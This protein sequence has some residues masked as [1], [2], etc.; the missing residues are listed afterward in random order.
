MSTYR[1]VTARSSLSLLL[2]CVSF[3]AAA[4]TQT[5]KEPVTIH[6]A[7][8]SLA[9]PSKIYQQWKPFADYIAETA[10]YPENVFG[11]HNDINPD[12]QQLSEIITGK[13]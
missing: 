12:L 1:S 10:K 13:Q 6:M 7:I 2:L 8:I 11:A 5:I 4:S 9:P 3:L